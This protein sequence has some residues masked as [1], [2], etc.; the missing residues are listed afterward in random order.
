M[1]ENLRRR[2][3][4]P[5]LGAEIDC[6]SLD[7]KTTPLTREGAQSLFQSLMEHKVVALRNTGLGSAGFQE[8]AR[9]IQAASLEKTS[10]SSPE[11]L[12]LEAF[13]NIPVTSKIHPTERG[14]IRIGPWPSKNGGAIG[15]ATWHSDGAYF[16]HPSWFTLLRMDKLPR[17][18]ETGEMLPCGDTMWADMTVAWEDLPE[19]E[20]AALAKL[21]V[22][23]DWKVAFPHVKKRAEEGRPGY[24]EQLEQLDQDFPSI[25]RPFVRRHP[26]T[27][28]M[29]LCA[30]PSYVSHI[31]GMSR[32][33]SLELLQR[34]MRLCEVPE[35][36]LRLP[37]HSETDIV[38]FDNYVLC[39]RVVADFYNIPPE[40]RLLEN[41]PTKGYP[42]P[43]ENL[44][45]PGVEI[46]SHNPHQEEVKRGR[47]A[48]S[49]SNYFGTQSSTSK[50]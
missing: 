16:Q 15:N 29:A 10:E 20:K 28:R 27:G 1:V 18:P 38:I 32:A 6:S 31:V 37:W 5:H 21:K 36:Q 25:E 17:D 3:L 50:M 22:V 11:Q 2:K 33:E 23:Y 41:I 35:Y 26:V 4:N 45:V 7:L 30:E 34:V 12:L 39:H 42:Q 13:P 43:L 48:F 14:I 9:Q 24:Q 8:L 49:S 40:S 44:L 46:D 19:E 47:A